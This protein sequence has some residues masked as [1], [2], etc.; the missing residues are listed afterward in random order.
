V[1]RALDALCGLLAAFALLAIMGLT[2][3]D[4]LGRKLLER[5]VPGALELTEIL[6]VVVIF[7]ALPLVSLHGEHV[8]FDSLDA[9]M[10]RGVLR[11]QQ[12]AVD[13]GC[14]LGLGGIAWLL[15]AKAAAL[16]SYGDTT[17]QLK[18]PLAPIVILMAAMCALAAAVHLVLVLRPAG[19]HLPGIDDESA[20]FG[21]AT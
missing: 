17:A 16:S 18:L 6:M 19:H 7:A 14:A 8:V 3:A 20:P 5:S 15:W 10:N 2:L 9:M 12:I 21:G 1:R 11:M 4:V 13:I